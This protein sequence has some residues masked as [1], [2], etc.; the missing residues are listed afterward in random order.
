M[1]P[2]AGRCS[3]SRRSGGAG[4]Q[5]GASRGLTA[6]APA[7]AAAPASA[8]GGLACWPARPQVLP[9]PCAWSV[10]TSCGCAAA[11]RL[12]TPSAVRGTVAAAAMPAKQRAADAAA[13]GKG[14]RGGQGGAWVGSGHV[15]P[16][17]SPSP[18]DGD[19]VAATAAGQTPAALSA[20]GL[21]AAAALGA[22]LA[23]ALAAPGA[24]YA[25][26]ALST[27]MLDTFKDFLVRGGLRIED[28]TAVERGE[29]DGGHAFRS[30]VGHASGEACMAWSLEP[31][32]AG[33]AVTD[34]IVSTT[35]HAQT[36]PV[37]RKFGL[38]R[39]FRC[40][41]SR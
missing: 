27:D 31:G 36:F 26:E 39:A 29:G 34:A 3:G 32:H 11:R 41:C 22:A 23:L 17:P 9:S 15:P 30:M 16:R 8:H 33:T 14:E 10:S 19:D 20:P 4:A 2:N 28:W 5:C 37:R 35:R 1:L 18:V 7:A 6:A 21:A 25:S 38:S 40:C 24:A 12:T 13:A